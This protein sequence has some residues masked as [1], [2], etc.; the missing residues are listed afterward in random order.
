MHKIL[1]YYK[2]FKV[3]ED[4]PLQKKIKAWEARMSRTEKCPRLRPLITFV[5]ELSPLHLSSMIE[6]PLHQPSDAT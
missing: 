6:L 1:I 2:V 3:E 4:E 5:Y